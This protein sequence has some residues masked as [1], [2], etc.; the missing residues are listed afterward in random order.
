MSLV[1]TL[2]R[3][4]VSVM[5]LF[6]CFFVK[7]FF[8]KLNNSNCISWAFVDL[9]QELVDFYQHNSLEDS[10]PE[11]KTTLLYPYKTFTHNNAGKWNLRIE[12]FLAISL[13]V[14]LT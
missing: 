6:I 2:S 1:Q 12:T 13:C 7:D 11:V 9:F 10:F 4:Y 8:L 5:H 3:F 14:Y